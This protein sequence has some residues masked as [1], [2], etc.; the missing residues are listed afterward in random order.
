MRWKRGDLTQIYRIKNRVEEIDINME[1]DIQKGN[2]G[3]RHRHQ[4]TRGVMGNVAMN[5]VSKLE[6]TNTLVWRP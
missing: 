3:R 6:L 2:S 5:V 4:I 1:S